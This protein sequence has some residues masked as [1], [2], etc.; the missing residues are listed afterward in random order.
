MTRARQTIS[1][2]LLVSSAYLL[3]A[4]PLLTN[5]SPIPSILPTKLQVE[6]IPVLPLWAIVSLGA[7]LLGR[8]GLG[9]IRFNDTEEAY[10]ELTAQLGAA[11]KSLD[12]RKV[13][14]D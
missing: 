10:K 3:L 6:I 4:L 14:W 8:L 7:Y 2:A 12:N 1:F 9:V 5:D 13:R 11:R